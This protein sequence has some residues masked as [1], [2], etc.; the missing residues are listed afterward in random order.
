MVYI[1][2]FGA[3][4]EFATF[5]AMGFVTG[6]YIDS[7]CGTS[8]WMS[9]VGFFLGAAAGVFS[10]GKT[11]REMSRRSRV[12]DQSRLRR[13]SEGG[14]SMV[15]FIRQP[16]GVEADADT[17]QPLSFTWKGSTYRVTEVKRT[18]KDGTV[19]Q[20][21]APKFG[22][23]SKDWWNEQGKVNYRVKTEDGHLFDL[24][25]D[26]RKSEWVLEKTLDL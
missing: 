16:V 14:M 21:G 10:V 13:V 20:I 18:W 11:V 25:F 9:V 22:A 2:Y 23:K 15:R 4:V 5:I 19:R 7:T 3:A 8:P 1:G 12:G 24:Q 6:A 26:S 17:G